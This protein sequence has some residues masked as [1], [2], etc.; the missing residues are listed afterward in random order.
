MA[1]RKVFENIVESKPKI[2]LIGY[3]IDIFTYINALL[4]FQPVN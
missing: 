4:R 1:W 3:V 2:G